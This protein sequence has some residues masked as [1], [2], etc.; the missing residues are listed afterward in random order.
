MRLVLAGVSALLCVLALPPYFIPQ[1]RRRF[2]NHLP[3][4]FAVA[5]LILSV[6]L[7]LTTDL[8][9][10]DNYN[11][12]TEDGARLFRDDAHDPT[13]LAQSVMVQVGLTLLHWYWL[14]MV[15]YLMIVLLWPMG[16]KVYLENTTLAVMSHAVPI[17]LSVGMIIY[18]VV[19]SHIGGIHFSG[20]CFWRWVIGGRLFLP[21][22][23]S[24]PVFIGTIFSCISLFAMVRHNTRLF[25]A[26]G[27]IEATV[28]DYWRLMVY[29]PW[30]WISLVIILAYIWYNYAIYDSVLEDLTS[31]FTCTI[32]SPPDKP[33]TCSTDLSQPSL[34]FTYIWLAL[35]STYAMCFAV[36]FG[37][38]MRVLKFWINVLTCKF[39]NAVTEAASTVDLKES[40]KQTS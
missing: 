21:V 38:N 5:A 19:D 3:A 13:C 40:N 14:L 22:W 17:T 10:V 33:R 15:A 12:V 11:C 9:D 39:E 23:Y 35:A 8:A 32:G 6:A 28:R 4:V 1:K 24:V 20:F 29:L 30:I 31:A 16:S 18:G 37:C 7:M 25:G 26:R 34:V 36:S 2:P 27:G